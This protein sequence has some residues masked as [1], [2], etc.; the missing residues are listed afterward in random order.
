MVSIA[1]RKR[2]NKG[3]KGKSRR[4]TVIGKRGE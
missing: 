1:K 3:R 4:E 2:D